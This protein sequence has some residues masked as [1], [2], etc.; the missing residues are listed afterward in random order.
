MDKCDFD[1]ETKE[2]L[3]WFEIRARKEK[4]KEEYEKEII[5]C[6]NQIEQ[7][8]VMIRI[9][10]Q[11]ISLLRQTSLNLRTVQ[12]IDEILTQISILT[13]QNHFLE[14]KVERLILLKNR[15]R[16]KIENLL[17]NV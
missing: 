16:Q 8:R 12:K 5:N 15:Y 17:N 10:A 6:I 2:F 7:D 3:Q 4:E 11:K 1:A 14:E 9:R 13:Q